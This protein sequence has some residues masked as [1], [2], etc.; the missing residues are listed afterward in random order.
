[1][2]LDINI[3]DGTMFERITFVVHIWQLFFELTKIFLLDIVPL[4]FN[5]RI[6][7]QIMIWKNV[8]K[9]LKLIIILYNFFLDQDF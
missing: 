2:I 9:F 1:M 8:K 4:I 7:L 3:V 5:R 6:S